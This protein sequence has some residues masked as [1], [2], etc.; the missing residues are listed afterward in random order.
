MRTARTEADGA[1]NGGAEAEAEAEAEHGLGEIKRDKEERGGDAA[2]LEPNWENNDDIRGRL[3]GTEGHHLPASDT[4]HTSIPSLPA[5]PPFDLSAL[6]PLPR[7][8]E[9]EATSRRRA[10]AREQA[11]SGRPSNSYNSLLIGNG[12]GD[13]EAERED[14]DKDKDESKDPSSRVWA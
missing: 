8:L 11:K 5:L 10:A 13:G 7:G 3:E 6:P 2:G 14:E 9:R 4:R 12:N 1:T